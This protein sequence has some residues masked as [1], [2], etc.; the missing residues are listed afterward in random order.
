[1]TGFSMDSPT[2]AQIERAREVTETKHLATVN[3]WRHPDGS[4]SVTF[5]D[6]RGV[7]DEIAGSGAPVLLCAMNALRA[8]VSPPHLKG[9]PNA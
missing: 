7:A 3:L 8:A 5:A 4:L 6:A 9:T 1:M 2:P